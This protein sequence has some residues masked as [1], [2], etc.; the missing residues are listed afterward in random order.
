MSKL[1]TKS[2]PRQFTAVLR[3][4]SPYRVAL[5]LCF[6]IV[7]YGFVLFRVNTLS[8]LQ[9]TD[10]SISA[11]YNPIKTSRIDPAVIKQLESLKDNSVSVQTLFDEARNN[12]FQE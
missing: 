12:P 6:I 4:L 10:A 9:P 3:Q 8:N 11:H 2:L 7:V 1:D 5:F